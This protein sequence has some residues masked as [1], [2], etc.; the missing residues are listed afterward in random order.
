MIRILGTTSLKL[1]Y[2]D[3]EIKNLVSTYICKHDVGERFSYVSL[4]KSIRMKALQE[5]MFQRK[6]NTE[7]DNI[8]MSD[9]DYNLISRILW[10]LIWDRKI[11]IEFHHSEYMANYN[12][13]TIFCVVNK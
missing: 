6:A 12:N 8:D 4:C 2:N 3:E 1:N 9:E 10:S 11:V 5:N 7:Y 13:D